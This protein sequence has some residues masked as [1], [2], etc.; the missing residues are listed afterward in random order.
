VT[1]VP[2]SLRTTAGPRWRSRP[3]APDARR[4]RRGEWIGT[5]G[6]VGLWSAG[7][8][9]QQRHIALYA[10]AVE[11]R[12][13]GDVDVQVDGRPIGTGHARQQ[14]VLVALLVEPN[15]AVPVEHLLRRVW[16]D[17]VPDGAS[18]NLR[19]Y[20]SRLRQALAGTDEVR[21]VRRPAGYLLAVDPMCVD[22]HRFR[23]MVEQARRTDDGQIADTCL[24]RALELWRGEAFRGLHTPWLSAYRETLDRERAAATLDRN[25]SALRAGQ[26]ARLVSDLL[27]ASGQHPWDERLAGQAMLALY[28]CGRQAEALEHF[29]R[30]RHRLADELGT[31]PSA[32]R[33]RL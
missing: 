2:M 17:E 28:R 5:L 12:I 33:P 10:V 26:H 3:T 19:S 27:T 30:M 6:S 16:G 13:L 22:L 32:A 4:A 25:D 23:D 1:V 18:A 14:C 9:V 8:V 24:E 29:H 21:I 31:D 20:L 7:F 11:F 15:R